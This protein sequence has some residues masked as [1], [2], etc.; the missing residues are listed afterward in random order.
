MKWSQGRLHRDGAGQSLK[1]YQE[2]SK[3]G[4]KAPMRENSPDKGEKVE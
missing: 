4:R 1:L 3:A 2:L